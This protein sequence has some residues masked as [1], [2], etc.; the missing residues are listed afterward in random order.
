MPIFSALATQSLPSQRARAPKPQCKK[1]TDLL[2]DS[3]SFFVLVFLA[4]EVVALAVEARFFG[5]TSTVSVFMGI[6]N[7]VI[8][9]EVCMLK[10][11]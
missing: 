7:S 9:G 4:R 3:S 2:L 1:T 10:I 8:V 11:G 5:F 6:S